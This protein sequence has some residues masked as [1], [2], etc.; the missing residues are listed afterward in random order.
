MIEISSRR[1]LPKLPYL[2][3]AKETKSNY[4][5]PKVGSFIVSPLEDLQQQ[6]GADKEGGAGNAGCYRVQQLLNRTVS[7]DP[8]SVASVILSTHTQTKN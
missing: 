8:L 5:E 2:S 1:V 3:L 4:G 7:C 6:K